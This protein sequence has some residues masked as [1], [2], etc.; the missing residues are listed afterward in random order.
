MTPELVPA[1][2]GAQRATAREFFAVAFRRRW[3]IIGL[4]LATMATVLT[5][6]LGAPQY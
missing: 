3:I 6:T 4:F 1:P 5:L 2:S